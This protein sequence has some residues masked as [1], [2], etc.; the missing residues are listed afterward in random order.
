MK[1]A[2]VTGGAGFIG[3][4]LCEALLEKKMRVICVDNFATGARENI[5][6]LKRNPDF[7]LLEQDIT[8]PF[9]IEGR[10]DFVFNLASPASP[11]DFAKMPV[12]IMLVNSIGTKN[13]L[14]IALAKKARFLEASTSEVYGQPLEHPQ[15]ETYWGNVNSIGM[16]SCYDEG[17]RFSEALA[18]A[19]ARNKGV[20]VRIA[21]IFNTYGPRMRL[22]DGRVTPNFITQALAEKPL[23][24]YGDGKQTR[25][26]CFVSDLVAG[27][28]KL[29]ESNYSGPVNIGNPQEI[30]VKQFAEAVLRISKSKSVLSFKK[31]PQDDPERRK[32]DISLAKKELGWEPKVSL[33]E[34]LCKTVEFFKAR[35]VF[36]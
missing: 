28:M 3:S 22:D 34:G 13:M 15:K 33:E 19:F 27:L 14:G 7:S 18:M 31:L 30:T 2:V 24:V 9:E 20:D 23:T 32:P 11:K 21:R 12:E 17:K 8:I 1:T 6:H 10:V 5:A 36:S 35:L 16:R 25:S 26:F 29:M 4:H